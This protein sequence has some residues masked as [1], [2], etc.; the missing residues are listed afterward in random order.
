MKPKTPREKTSSRFLEDETNFEGFYGRSVGQTLWFVYRSAVPGL[1][2]AVLIG[3]AAR[4]ILLFNTNLMGYWADS[5]CRGADCRPLPGWAQNFGG[6]DYVF[7]LALASGLGLALT[8]LFRIAFSRISAR[9]VSVFYDEVTLRTS[10]LPM[11]FFDRT[12]VGRIVTRFSSDYGNIFRMFGGPLAEFFGILFDI[13]AGFLLSTYASPWFAPLF[14]LLAFMNYLVY[15]AN[16]GA[17]RSTRRELSKGRSPSIA[18]FAETTQ[19]ASTI[20]VFGREKAFFDRFRGLDLNF[21]SQK[22]RTVVTTQWFSW[23]MTTTTAFVV[24]LTGLLGYWLVETGRIGVGSVG[25][26]LGFMTLSGANLQQLFD[27]VAQLE[28]ALTGVERLDQYLRMDLEAGAKLP[29]IATYP[30]EHPRTPRGAPTTSPLRGHRAVDVSVEDLSLRYGPD[31]PPVLDRL[32]FRIEAGERLGVIGRTGSGKSSLIQALLYLY[33]FEA[34]SIRV[35][36]YR[37]HLDLSRPPHNDELDLEAYRQTIALITQDPVLFRGTLR[38]NLCL[39]R[40]IADEDLIAV[41]DQVGLGIWVRE[42]KAGL[43]A[44]IEERARNLSL[45]E[46]QLLCMARCA[47]QDVPVVIMDEATSAI[48]PQSEELLVRATERFFRDRTQIIIAHRLSTLESCDRIL[49]L[50][51]GRIRMLGKPLDVLGTFRES[52]LT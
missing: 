16:R 29:P 14:L 32:N 1:S 9:A 3:F 6:A 26:A 5:R 22:L 39:G 51:E 46:R 30:T 24:L 28:D 42:Q 45:G 21:L 36:G 18:H 40:D 4:L 49:W 43:M 47:L 19:G 15:R 20:R 41:L 2:A 25:V 52:S 48:D 12:P 11:S 13:F 33:P 7:W 38:E 35:G 27:W 37:P 10:R 8:I 50:H 44:P 23:Q 31:L 34:G 17:I